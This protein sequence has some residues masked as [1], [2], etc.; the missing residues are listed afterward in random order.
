MP[1]NMFT[2]LSLFALVAPLMVSALKLATPKNPTSSG[3]I[4]IKWT[5]E[6]NDPDT[7]SF[8]LINQSF[9]NEFAI[10]NNVNPSASQLTLTLPIVPTG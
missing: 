8:V 5:N 3:T 9:N 2:K 1:C 7:W 10:A 6:P 4:T